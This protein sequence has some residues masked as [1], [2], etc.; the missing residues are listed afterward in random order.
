[1]FVYVSCKL[2]TGSFQP[3]F[4]SADASQQVDVSAW[5]FIDMGKL[6]FD[7]LDTRAN[8]GDKRKLGYYGILF[9]LSSSKWTNML[10]APRVKETFLMTSF[11]NAYATR[12]L[13]A[14]VGRTA[15]N[16]EEI[17]MVKPVSQTSLLFTLSGG[18][19]WSTIIRKTKQNKKTQAKKS[20]HC[21]D[22][23]FR[24]LQ[25]LPKVKISSVFLLV[26]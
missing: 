15:W 11:R 12:A 25:M 24:I 2:Q 5:D 9:F 18:D 4:S 17:H 6:R 16:P 22:I 7:C 21:R 19:F 26:P 8:I 13:M 23:L 10:I 20:T 1:M 14:W 3:S